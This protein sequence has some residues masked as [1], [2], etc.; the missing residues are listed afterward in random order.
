MI[1]AT[2]EGRILEV[3]TQLEKLFGQSREGITG[4]PIEVLLPPRFRVKHSAHVAGF[5]RDSKARAMGSGLE[6]YGLRSDGTEF[7]VEISLSPMESDDGPL[8]IAA[9]RDVT[10][11]KE[12][13]SRLQQQSLV[14]Q[15]Q[16]DLLDVAH[17]SIMVRD[18]KG[19][20]SFWNRGA[21]ATYGWT[22]EEAI[23]R[24][25]HELLK[26]RFPIPLDE[27]QEE[28]KRERR[29][30]GELVHKR[31]DGSELIVASRWVL[32]DDNPEQEKVLEIN[33]DISRRK[34]AEA[35]QKKAVEELEAFTYTA[36]QDLRAPLRHMHGFANLLREAWY[37][38]LDD[39]GK[40]LL[41]KVLVSSVEM[42]RLLDDLLT[43]SRLGRVELSR[44]PVDLNQ[45]VERARE[46]IESSADQQNGRAVIWEIDKLPTVRGDPSLLH[47]VFVNLLSN[48][49]KYSRKSPSPQITVGARQEG[50][51]SVTLF[52]RDN[53]TGF[54]MAYSHKLFRVFQRLHRAKDYEGTGIG[55]AIVRQ[56]VE[57]HGGRVWA[58]SS[59][60]RGATFF[61]SL[62]LGAKSDEQF[63]SHTAGR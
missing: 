27:I 53:G 29:W 1:I 38:R 57:R 39:D 61:F 58:E 63:R 60:G 30:E 10:E 34:I 54:D 11:H 18:L 52:V 50:S 17:D 16:A 6:L 13:E 15:Q 19:V 49:V 55:L 59:P 26:T 44:V 40:R 48:A 3:N 4:S 22:K 62:P 28:L 8:V 24:V 36:A 32:K 43:F 23:G 42:G 5:F 21:E 12:R 2:S 33:N 25:T 35:E 31:R 20:L 51:E 37:E 7:P 41:E 47:Q 14:L 56:V 9:V 46:A 45:L